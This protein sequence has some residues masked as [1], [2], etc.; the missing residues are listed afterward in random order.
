M[1]LT[2]V[3]PCPYHSLVCSLFVW[4]LLWNEGNEGN[5]DTKPLTVQ[6]GAA[7][8]SSI[9]WDSSPNARTLNKEQTSL[10][11]PSAAVF[12]NEEPKAL[13]ATFIH[14]ISM[15]RAQLSNA[16]WEDKLGNTTASLFRECSQVFSPGRVEPHTERASSALRKLF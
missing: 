2:Q 3:Q 6:E 5:V 16:L 11:P 10:V 13:H 14:P 7:F 4:P 15:L 1:I 8:K 12:L 9:S